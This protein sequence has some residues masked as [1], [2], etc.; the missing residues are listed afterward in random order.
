MFL[1]FRI[2]SFAA[3]RRPALPLHLR[4]RRKASGDVAA[5]EVTWNIMRWPLAAG[6]MRAGEVRRLVGGGAYR[7]VVRF[8]FRKVSS[9]SDRDFD[10]FR[11]HTESRS[12][13][14]LSLFDGQSA[15]FGF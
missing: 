8:W 1:A 10:L 13:L 7:S 4:I 12:K 2:G 5:R 15:S 14:A 3:L 11:L 9:T 6:R